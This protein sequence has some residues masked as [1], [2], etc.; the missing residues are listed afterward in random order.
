MRV[1]YTR[2]KSMKTWSTSLLFVVSLLF[3]FTLFGLAAPTVVSATDTGL[4]PCMG[5]E[6]SFC[7]L[8]QLGN[9]VISWIFGFV[10]VVFGVITFIAGFNLI[11]SGG[12]QSKLDDAKSKLS[13]AVV[14]LIIVFAAWLVVDTLVK[15]LLPGETGDVGSALG[16]SSLGPWNRLECDVAAPVSSTAEPGWTGWVSAGL[17]YPVNYGSG[18]WLDEPVEFRTRVDD[19]SVRQNRYCSRREPED[20][21]TPVTLSS[22]CLTYE[23]L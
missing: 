23:A 19:S 5:A 11:T 18:I 16:V 7:H 9:N 12:N 10:F 21:S 13:N 14:G 8:V 22:P 4:I 6:C 1:G 17:T 3:V 20:S 2:K 15:A